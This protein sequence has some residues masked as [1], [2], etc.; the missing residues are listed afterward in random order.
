[1]NQKY[2]NDRDLSNYPDYIEKIYEF[3]VPSGQLPE[4]LDSYITRNIKYGS[5]TKVRKAIDSGSVTVNGVNCKAGQKI[6]PGDSIICKIMKPP[7]IELIPENI[8]LDILFED[9]YL[10]VVNKPPGMASHPGFGNRRGTLV[11]A[12]LWHLGQRE[13][14]SVDDIEEDE[15]DDDESETKTEGEIFAGEDVRPGLVHRLDKDTSGILVISKESFIQ[16]ELQKQ[17]RERTTER[18]YY[19]LVWGIPEKDKGTIEGDIG[20]SRRDRKLFAV[21]K[22]DGKPSLTEY[23]VLEKHEHTSLLKIKLQTGRT[24][25]I[26]VHTSYIN[27]PIFGDPTYGGRSILRGGQNP[28]YKSKI[29]KC[30]KTAGRQMLHAKTL[31]FTHPA[32]KKRL[33]FES[34]LPDDF[35]EVLNILRTGVS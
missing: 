27:H 26:R 2:E 34:P 10:M 23:E 15:T 18:F 31:A 20:R 21:V 25:Q 3:L 4:R 35:A 17:F 24:H 14:L 16:T 7:P 6:K 22:K 30:L 9:E 11:N 13:A 32:A 19:A 5:R 12:V 33:S 28:F 1:M 8:P 29:Q